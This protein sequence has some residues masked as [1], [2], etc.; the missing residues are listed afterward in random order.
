MDGLG[1]ALAVL[2]VELTPGPNMAWLVAL[3]LAEGRR[4]GCMAAAGV[5]L[6]LAINVA[7]AGAGLGALLDRAPGLGAGLGVAAGA[8]MLW[9]AWRGWTAPADAPATHTTAGTRSL[10][11]VVTGLVLNVFNA[12]AALFFLTVAPR[13]LD[14]APGWREIAALGLI[15]VGVATLVHLGLVFGAGG[16]RRVLVR[17]SR[18]RR[19]RRGLALGMAAVGL[20]FLVAAIP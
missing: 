19:V 6:G 5:A 13:F 9:L 17:P 10:H 15:S 16:V 18:V 2:L 4:A 14:A 8:M 3:T 1:F 11:G 20:W 12:K 7:L